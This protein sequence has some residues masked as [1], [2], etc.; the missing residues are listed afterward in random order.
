MQACIHNEYCHGKK[1]INDLFKKC[2]CLSNKL[3][4][5]EELLSW[6]YINNEIYSTDFNA[7]K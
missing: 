1:K 5:V 7:R 2:S 4:L 3:F 6:E